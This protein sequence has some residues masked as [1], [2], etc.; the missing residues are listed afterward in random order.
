MLLKLDGAH[1]L[2]A[3]RIRLSG[4]RLE[5]QLVNATNDPHAI[6]RKQSDPGYV[7][8]VLHLLC[9]PHIA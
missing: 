4:E 2:N 7:E 3:L 5:H 1:S 6:D 8:E 9:P